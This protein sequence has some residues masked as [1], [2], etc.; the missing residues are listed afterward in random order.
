[1]PKQLKNCHT[2]LYSSK[3]VVIM[4]PIPIASSSIITQAINPTK[5]AKVIDKGL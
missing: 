2:P 4:E 1:M 5:S 3:F